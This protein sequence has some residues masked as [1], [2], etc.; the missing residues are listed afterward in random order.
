MALVTHIF[1]L[2]KGWVARAAQGTGARAIKQ[3]A[4]LLCKLKTDHF[5]VIEIPELSSFTLHFRFG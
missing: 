4:E 1:Y 2:L 3:L 5:V